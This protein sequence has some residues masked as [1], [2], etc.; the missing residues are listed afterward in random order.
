MPDLFKFTFRGDDNVCF[1][2]GDFFLKTYWI[3]YLNFEA[4]NA[5]SD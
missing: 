1:Y 3:S 5:L 2:L 4:I